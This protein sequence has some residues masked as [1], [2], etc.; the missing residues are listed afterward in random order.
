[1]ATRWGYQGE[2]APENWGKI[3]GNEICSLGKHQ[4]PVDIKDTILTPTAPDLRFHFVSDIA[5]IIHNGHS[6]QINFALGNQL[7]VGDTP[8]NLLQMHFHTPS[9]FWIQGKQFPMEAHF[10]HRSEKGSLLVFGVM[11]EEGEKN[12]V[13]QSIWDQ[14]PQKICDKDHIEHIDIAPL[15]AN[16]TGYYQLDGSLTTP[17]CSEGVTW[18]ISK[19]TIQASKEQF[20]TFTQLIGTNNRPLQQLNHRLII[21]K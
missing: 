17:P 13:I 12:A 9:E 15:V 10:V 5:E 1:M 4:V 16:T 2:F 20:S 21:E 6:I 14:M 3:H 8:Y 19:T 18:I 11:F 7:F